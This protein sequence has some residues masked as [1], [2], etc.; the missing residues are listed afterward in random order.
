M[1]ANG[2]IDPLRRDFNLGQEERW[3]IQVEI[4]PE[5]E[6]SLHKVR[7]VDFTWGSLCT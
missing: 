4:V 7:K 3:Q 2:E 6:A 5:F 1:V